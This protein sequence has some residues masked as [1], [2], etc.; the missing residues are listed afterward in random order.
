MFMP[1]LCIDSN[2]AIITSEHD[3]IRA[4]NNAAQYRSTA[5][6]HKVRCKA[7][8]CWAASGMITIARPRN[9]DAGR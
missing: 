7:A 2:I 4:L 3:R 6:A 5:F 9:A 1:L 8:P